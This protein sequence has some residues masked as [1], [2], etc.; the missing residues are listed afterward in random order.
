MLRVYDVER[1]MLCCNSVNQLSGGLW[2]GV[3][4]S[5]SEL[6]TEAK[7]LCAAQTNVITVGASHGVCDA[8]SVVTQRQI[9]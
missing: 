5:L 9:S 6:S 4:L 3:Y 1:R 7:P 8:K 2:S